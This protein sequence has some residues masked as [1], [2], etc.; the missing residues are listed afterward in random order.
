MADRPE[1]FGL[2]AEV[3]KKLLAKYDE[4]VGKYL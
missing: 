2:T 4:K 1:G 3:R